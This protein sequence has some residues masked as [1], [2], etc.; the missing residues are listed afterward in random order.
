MEGSSSTSAGYSESLAALRSI[1][2]YNP[3]RGCFAGCDSEYRAAREIVNVP[4]PTIVW[5]FRAHALQFP[6]AEGALRFGRSDQQDCFTIHS[7]D[8]KEYLD[9]ARLVLDHGKLKKSRTG[10]E[11]AVAPAGERVIEL[12]RRLARDVPVA[13]SAGGG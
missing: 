4:A 12:A 7:V 5:I 3:V 2:P 6:A 9:L 1:E 10:I 13:K 11:Q 8:M